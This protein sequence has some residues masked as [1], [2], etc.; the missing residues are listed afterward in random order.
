MKNFE[1]KTAS[2]T[3]LIPNS[4]CKKCFPEKS[5]G[6]FKIGKVLEYANGKVEI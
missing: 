3:K 1:N 2:F 5:E 4:H 6:A